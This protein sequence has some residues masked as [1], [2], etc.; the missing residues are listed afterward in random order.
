MTYFMKKVC[1]TLEVLVQ[2]LFG[3]FQ[4]ETNVSKYLF[5]ITLGKLVLDFK[6]TM[7]I[8]NLGHFYST[9][10][11]QALLFSPEDGKFTFGMNVICNCKLFC[12]R[13]LHCS[14]FL[15][16][17]FYESGGLLEVNLYNGCSVCFI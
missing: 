13:F 6:Y 7:L 15:S 3:I 14:V 2:L 8:I 9:V 11:L 12:L 17:Y 10:P 5:K 16:K 1:S 4:L